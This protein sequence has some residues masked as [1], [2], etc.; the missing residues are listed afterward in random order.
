MNKEWDGI[1]SDDVDA[2]YQEMRSELTL[3]MLLDRHW[4]QAEDPLLVMIDRLLVMMVV[5]VLWRAQNG[6]SL[7]K[8]TR[9]VM[10]V[11]REAGAPRAFLKDI[12]P[13]LGMLAYKFALAPDIEWAVEEIGARLHAEFT[14][15]FGPAFMA[16]L[17]RIQDGGES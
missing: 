7:G 6:E 14:A 2:S 16:Q 5:E 3:K 13:G 1:W 11:W 4:N 9:A 10:K 12:E 15:K 17:Q 8:A